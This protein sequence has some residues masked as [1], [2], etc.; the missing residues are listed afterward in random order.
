MVQK[1]QKTSQ[2]K[3]TARFQP[4]GRPGVRFRPWLLR[5]IHC[6]ISS[7]MIPRAC[8]AKNLSGPDSC[9]GIPP[10]AS[11]TRWKT[12]EIMKVRLRSP[13]RARSVPLGSRNTEKNIKLARAEKFWRVAWCQKDLVYSQQIRDLYSLSKLTPKIGGLTSTLS[14]DCIAEATVQ[15]FRGSMQG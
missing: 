7:M 6:A 2:R 9:H 13:Y 5:Y 10:A 1:S 15:P 3:P 12:P 8:I 14:K 11:P 4:S